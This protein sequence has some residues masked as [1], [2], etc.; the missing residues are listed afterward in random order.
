MISLEAAVL[1]S[2]D[3]IVFAKDLEG[4]YIAGNAAWAQLLGR[5]LGE[6]IGLSDGDLFPTEVAAGF[7]AHDAAMLASGAAAMNEEWVTYPDG[8]EALLETRKCPLRDGAGV[9][10]GMVGVCREI[11]APR[12]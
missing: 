12:R 2:I 8:R 10:I 9:V 1:Q 5:D 6:L 7:L 11:Q 3:D 4:R